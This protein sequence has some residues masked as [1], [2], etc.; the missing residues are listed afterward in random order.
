MLQAKQSLIY[1]RKNLGTKF[2][3]LTNLQFSGRIKQEYIP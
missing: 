3:E 1:K 2:Q